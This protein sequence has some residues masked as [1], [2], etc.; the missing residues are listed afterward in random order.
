MQNFKWYTDK[1]LKDHK[2]ERTLIFIGTLVYQANSDAMKYFLK[3][4]Y[5]KIKKQAEKVNLILV[6]WHRPRWP[7]CTGRP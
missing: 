1:K 3:E 5:P 4:I 7:R 2:K 6:S